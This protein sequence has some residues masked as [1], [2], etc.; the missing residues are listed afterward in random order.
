VESVLLDL[1]MALKPGER[2]MSM[3]VPNVEE[4]IPAG[5]RYRKLLKVIDWVELSRPLRGLYSTLGRRGYS[6]EQGLKCLFLQFLED[7]SDRQMECYL[8]ENLAAKFFCNFGLTEQ[9]PDS[10]YF[11]RFRERV[12]SERLAELFKRITASLKKLGLVREV[13][14]FVDSAKIV[15]CVDTWKARDKA[16]EDIENKERDDDDNPTM[17]NQNLEQYSSDP[18]ARFGVKGKNNIWLGYKRHLAVDAHQGLVSQ[19]AVTPG[20]TLDGN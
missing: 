15:A 16:L 2:Q 9:T 4:L 6:V 19:V 17:N 10:T 11:C 14:T 20:V 13:Y 12:G 7:R 1:S 3:L 5:H 8:Q 18:E